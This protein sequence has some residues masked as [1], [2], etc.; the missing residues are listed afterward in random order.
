MSLFEHQSNEFIPR[1]IGP[2]EQETKQMLK[3]IGVSSL[4]ELVNQ[5]VPAGIRM[6]HSLSIPPP[7]GEHEYLEH[8]KEISLRNKTFTNYIGQG[9]YDTIIPSVILRTVFEN[10]GWYTQY[11]PY[12]AEIS[13]GRL[14]SLLNFQTMV[15]D[16]TGLPISNASLL[17]EAT[18]AAEAMTM[19]FNSLNK[20]DHIERHR[21]FV[22]KEIGRAHV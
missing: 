11:T 5:T 10:P 12:Q 21:F 13:Q 18:A 22:D 16:L 1:H 15:S 6:D 2:N 4:D 14:E 8:I 19:F 3:T 17:D 20:Q 7:M 9:Y